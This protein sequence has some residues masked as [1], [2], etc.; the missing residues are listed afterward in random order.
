MFSFVAVIGK[1]ALFRTRLVKYLSLKKLN[2]L[3]LAQRSIINDLADGDL[4]QVIIVFMNEFVK[5]PIL[6]D[7]FF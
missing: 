4:I 5:L 2:F 1:L 6:I 3:S 7:N